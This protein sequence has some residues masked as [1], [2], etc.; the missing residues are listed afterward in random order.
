GDDR[1]VPGEVHIGAETRRGRGQRGQDEIGGEHDALLSEITSTLAEP[2]RGRPIPEVIAWRNGRGH[3]PAALLRGRG[4]G[5]QPD[6]GG[7]AAVYGAAF[8]DQAGQAVGGETRDPAVR[9]L[10]ERY[11][12]D[13]TRPGA[14]R[15]GAAAARH[16]RYR[17]TG[18]RAGGQGIA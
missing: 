6:P 1:G 16:A 14:G 10:P 18:G 13:R 2:V 3:P 8:A 15:P 4:A 17:G 11:G 7:A 5:G 9:P 12:P